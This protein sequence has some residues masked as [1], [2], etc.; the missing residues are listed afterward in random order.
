MTQTSVRYL[1]LGDSYTIGADVDPSDSWPTQLAN[2]LRQRGHQ[3]SETVIVAGNGWTTSDLAID[4]RQSNLI[5]TFD[6]V[7][8]LIGVNNQYRGLAEDNYRNEFRALLQ[9]AIA[10]TGGDSSRVLVLS[11]PDWSVTPF[12]QNFDVEV[13]A[14]E[15]DSFNIINRY[16]TEA[17]GARYINITPESRQA[18]FNAS[19]IAPDGLHPS[20]KMYASWARLVLPAALAVLAGEKP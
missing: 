2:L 20:G 9:Q 4:L 14:A 15:I 13:I 17:S 5:G 12:A 3:I 1:A 18:K 11:I 7:S 10:L 19:L 8:L 6:L 16:E